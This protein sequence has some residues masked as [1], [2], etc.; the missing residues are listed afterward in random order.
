MVNF[1]SPDSTVG[2][3]TVGTAAIAGIATAK[4]NIATSA[5]LKIIELRFLVP[6]VSPF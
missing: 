3:V 1:V 5:T 6:I 2:L 4:A